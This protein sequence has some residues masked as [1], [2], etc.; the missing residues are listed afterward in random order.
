MTRL[1]LSVLAA[2]IAVSPAHA[3]QAVYVPELAVEAPTRLDWIYPLLG[4]SPPDEP[5]GLLDGYSSRAQKYEFYGPP[6]ADAGRSYPLIL[7]ASPSDSPVGWKHFGPMC[8][9]HGVLFAGPREAGNGRPL[10]E[11]VRVTLDVLDDVRRRYQVDPERTYI[12]G[13]S[14]G[15]A[16]A[17]RIAY[18]LPEYFGG[19]VVIGHI[20]D[21]PSER[22][23]WHRVRDRLSVAL[24]CGG[25]EPI[26]D[27]VEKLQAPLHE[28]LGIRASS[29]AVPSLGHAMPS[30]AVCER[31]YQW[32]EQDVASRERFAGQ[33][34]AGSFGVPCTREEWAE[35]LLDEAKGRLAAVENTYE[36]AVQ[37]DW[38][39]RRW[40]DLPQAAEAAM[41]R[42]DLLTDD[43]PSWRTGRGAEDRQWLL[44]HAQVCEAYANAKLDGRSGHTRFEVAR[45]AI[46]HWRK[47][48]AA[49]ADETERE[50]IGQR[51]A[52][53]EEIVARAP[54]PAKAKPLPGGRVTFHGSMSVRQ[55]LDFLSE[56]YGQRGFEFPADEE[57]I[58]AAGLSLDAP[59]D[60]HVEKATL[61]QLLEAAL[62]PAGLTFRRR[63]NSFRIV[64]A[65]AVRPGES[66]FEKERRKKMS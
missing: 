40:P 62:D 53:L 6:A 1:S 37:L 63:G 9:R 23:H 55:L 66:T 2:S 42:E 31:A 24:I 28:A 49:T 61:E 36:G 45:A 20:L 29:Y 18:H 35:K 52:S 27:V 3:Q 51:I 7:F 65:D 48:A 59:L 33:Y 25:R 64:P 46:G 10:P 47:L 60:L 58:A 26:R 43:D 17:S 41:L 19:L 57:A 54:P 22:W 5:E 56:A 4:H 13:F 38:I 16:V 15:A 12:A 30:S 34:P 39:A 21:P 14:G 11:R 32:L 8:Q 44:A 50:E